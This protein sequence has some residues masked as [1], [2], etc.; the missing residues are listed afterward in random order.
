MHIFNQIKTRI[1]IAI[2]ELIQDKKEIEFS[3]EPPKNQE[4]GDIA[5][6]A[7]M[8]IAKSISKKPLDIAE[9]L[10]DILKRDNTLME[11]VEKFTIA[12]PG[13]INMYL[14]NEILYYFL[15]NLN[16][17]GPTIFDKE[18][19]IGLDTKIN[20]EF[21]SANPTGPMHIGNARSAIYGNVVSRLL[22]KCGFDITT[23]YYIN[24]GGSQTDKLIETLYIRYRQLQGESIE[25]PEG[26]YPGEYVIDTAKQLL[27]EHG[28]DLDQFDPKLRKF[29]IDQ[30]MILIKSNLASLGV[31]H[32]IFTSEARLI[33]DG[34]V[35]E[36]IACLENKGLLYKGI[37]EKPKSDTNQ[38]WEPREQLL[39]RSTDF[40]DDSDRALL[41]SD[42]S[43]TYFASDVALHLDK[44]RR[45][46]DQ[47]YLILGADHA[48][49]VN[50]IR[51]S[52]KAMTDNNMDLNIIVNQLVNIY[53][54]GKPIRMSKRKGNVITVDDVLDEI[55]PD[56]L[57]FAMLSQ[58]NSTVLDID[59]DKL[60]E[61][62][63]D[64]H[65]FYIQYAHTR[66]VSIIRNGHKHGIF[67]I[68]ELDIRDIEGKLKY[69]FKP[70]DTIDYALLQSEIDLDVIKALVNFPRLLELSAKHKEPHRII[71]YLYNLAH[72]LH[73]LWH[74]GVVEDNMRCILDDN[75]PLSRAR[76]SLIYGLALILSDGLD[77]F[78]VQP[79]LTM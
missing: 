13:F 63:S 67:S 11:F 41:K 1:A 70:N 29:A 19:N 58:K 26:C 47:L 3:V 8:V 16:N 18:I 6:N 56:I 46:Y 60:L 31:K 27:A 45:G 28:K 15:N 69:I 39:F 72:K 49:Y 54:D 50:R 21:V 44:I 43:Y 20:L 53:K 75:I 66:I 35:E 59:C 4:Y 40:G 7:S 5:T 68:D 30:M 62:S 71:Y 23:E 2:E 64:N 78:G 17:S 74:I 34:L 9:E 48:G 77:I 10:I 51:A 65:L 55:S 76:I 32:D 37:L 22:K 52:V 73:N 12:N 24:D 79:L 38:D 36:A 61:K 25:L 33:Q 57:C 42:G 14:K